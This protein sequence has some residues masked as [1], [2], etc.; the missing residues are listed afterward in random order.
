LTTKEVDSAE[1]VETVAFTR[2]DDEEEEDDE[3]GEE[4]AEEEDEEETGRLVG[5]DVGELVGDEVELDTIGEE[6]ELD[7]DTGCDSSVIAQGVQ[8]IP[9]P[10]L[11]GLMNV[12]LMVIVGGEAAGLIARITPRV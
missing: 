5:D 1:M 2:G 11:P 12:E 3:R 6:D 8:G 10:E 4:E 9:N 7:D